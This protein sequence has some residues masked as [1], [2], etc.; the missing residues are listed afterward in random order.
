MLLDCSNR[1][2]GAP[3]LTS[4]NV[5]LRIRTDIATESR[6]LGKTKSFNEAIMKRA[7]RT[8]PGADMNVKLQLR[9]LTLS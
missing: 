6:I 2:D 4:A 5:H 3:D 8:E 1:Q 7:Y 9:K